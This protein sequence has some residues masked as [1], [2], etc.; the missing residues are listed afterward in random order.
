VGVR[1]DLKSLNGESR[2]LRNVLVLSLTLLLLKL[3]RDTTDGTSL[4][5]LHQ[6]GGETGNLVSQTLR[7]DDGDFIADS[8]VGLEV[9]SETGVVLLN[10]DAG[11]LLDGFGTDATLLISIQKVQ[12]RD[13]AIGYR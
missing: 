3:E 8:L 11:G 9:K 5:T 12:H 1:V 10:D 13:I 2:D 6:V 4:N 7:G